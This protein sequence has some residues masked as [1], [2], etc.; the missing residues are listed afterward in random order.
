[1]TE[2]SLSELHQW[3]Q[4]ALLAKGL[5]NMGTKLTEQLI[6][7]APQMSVAHTAFFLC[8]FENPQFN[9]CSL[10]HQNQFSVKQKH[11]R[12]S[13][14]L[15][16]SWHENSKRQMGQDLREE[17]VKWHSAGSF[18]LLFQQRIWSF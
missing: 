1:M 18:C 6:V 8:L 5:K 16:H 7:R 14:H 11:G 15:C 9:T 2:N 17:V 3:Q 13:E 10:I 12:N 4:H